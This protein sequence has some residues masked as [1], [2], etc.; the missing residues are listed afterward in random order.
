MIWIGIGVGVFVIASIGVLVIFA[1]WKILRW[2]K[3]R[4]IAPAPKA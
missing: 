4:F 1:A 3:N 2:L